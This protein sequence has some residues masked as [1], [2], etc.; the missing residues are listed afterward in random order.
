MSS[1]AQ[2]EQKDSNNQFGFIVG[3]YVSYEFKTEKIIS[4]PTKWSVEITR[5]IAVRDAVQAVKETQ[6]VSILKINKAIHEKR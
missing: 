3:E 5:L 2:L 1:Q 4:F 6:L